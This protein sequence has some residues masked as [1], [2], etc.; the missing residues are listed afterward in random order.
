[1]IGMYLFKRSLFSLLLV[2]SFSAVSSDDVVNIE[3]SNDPVSIQKEQDWGIAAVVRSSTIPYSAA[4]SFV[5]SFIP[6]MFY[7]GER[8]YIKGLE[9]GV[10]LRD[11]SDW[12]M[13]AILRLRFF[14]L[15][16]S[17]QNQVKGD[18]GDGGIQLRRHL[19]DTWD[20]DTEFM[21]DPSYRWHA[22]TR[23][24]SEIESGDWWFNPSLELRWKSAE[25]NSYY[26]ALSEFSNEEIGAGVDVKLG[27]MTRYHVASN[28]YLLGGAYVTR[29]DGHAFA[30]EN[31]DN[32]WQGEFY[33]G[34]G[35]F[36][37]KDKPYRSDLSNKPYVRVAH[38]WATPS[39]IGD[40]ISGNSEKDEFNNQLSSVFYGHP[41]TD[42]LFGVP[43]D[44]YLTPGLVWHWSSEV[45]ASSPEYVM[46]IKA[47]ANISW[48]TKW[49][50][51]VAEGLSYINNITYIEQTEMD[52]KGYRPSELLN[53][54]DFS[55][56]VNLGD[57]FNY[58]EWNGVWLGYSIHHRS[59]IFEKASQYGR[60]K[61]GSNY[62][63]VYLQFDF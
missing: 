19:N 39:N 31:I 40:I 5:S 16:Q 25:F 18:V 49:R 35:L 61:G 55:V 53:Y 1:M 28:L 56:D 42:E 15:P 26:Y 54:L 58:K 45:Q 38:G 59:A 22:N 36:K 51:G 60:I 41:L 14:D 52:E 7:E 11:Y 21:L 37:N 48:P 24:S 47:Y 10:T 12:Q 34:F 2:C 32:Q 23:L 17:I 6:L 44:I 46:A 30:S 63:T 20:L 9:G 57:L 8:F 3:V 27:A 13:N 29:L 4:D 62:N 33:V 50:F 43:V